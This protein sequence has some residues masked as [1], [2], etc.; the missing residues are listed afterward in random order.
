[1][2]GSMTRSNSYS[3][4]KTEAKDVF[5]N[6]QKNFNI[7]NLKP[8]IYKS[9]INLFPKYRLERMDSDYKLR[10]AYLKGDI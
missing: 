1:M 2:T 9:S 5:Q 8:K 7:I 10:Q 6:Q 4:F 3:H